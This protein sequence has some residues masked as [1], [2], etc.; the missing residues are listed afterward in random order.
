MID[1]PEFLN[2]RIAYIDTLRR[3]GRTIRWVGFAAI[4]GGVGL[5]FWSHTTPGAPAWTI[6][7]GYALMGAGWVAFI[8]VVVQRARW[9]RA[10]PF[11]PS[12]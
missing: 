3:M 4:M 12:E 7:L 6:W 8:Y 11:D 10:N 5:I 1:D 2:R 9:A